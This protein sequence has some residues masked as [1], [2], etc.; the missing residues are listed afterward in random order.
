[1]DAW[2]PAFLQAIAAEAETQA[3]CT[4]DL[5]KAWKVARWAVSKKRKTSQTPAAVDI[6]AASPALSATTLASHLGIAV[7]NASRILEDLVRDGVVIEVSRRTKRRIYSLP[8]VAP[9][10]EVAA[11]PRRPEPFRGRGRPRAVAD[12]DAENEAPPLP[13]EEA[14]TPLPHVNFDYSGLDAAMASMEDAIKRTKSFLDRAVTM[15]PPPH[16][17]GD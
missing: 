1:M 11:G 3:Q 13:W 15:N 4:R 8:S 14:S 6:L 12:L 7:K 10:R 9:L 16:Y 2:L 5:D 17:D